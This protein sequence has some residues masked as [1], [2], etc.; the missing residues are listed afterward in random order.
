MIFSKY[1]NQY[2]FLKYLRKAKEIIFKDF[3]DGKDLFKRAKIQ[4]YTNKKLEE[5]EKK[6]TLLNDQTPKLNKSCL[7]NCSKIPFP[8]IQSYKE[9][10]SKKMKR[11]SMNNNIDLSSKAKNKKHFSKVQIMTKKNQIK[12]INYKRSNSACNKYDNNQ[13]ELILFGEKLSYLKNNNEKSYLNIIETF[14]NSSISPIQKSLNKSKSPPINPS[15]NYKKSIR[16][17]KLVK[18]Q[19]KQN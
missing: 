3:Y 5:K 6:R 16:K 19:K 14:L 7:I 2:N 12:K 13:S 9:E 8:K 18:I 4:T 17:I 10:Y 15:K 11:K 1:D